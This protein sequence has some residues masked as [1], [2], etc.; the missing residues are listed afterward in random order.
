MAKLVIFGATG[1]AG[2]R[3]GAEAR[4]RGHD[5]VG[6]A[7]NVDGISGDFTARAGS[8]HDAPFVAEVAKGADVLVVATPAREDADGRKLLDAVP[9]LAKAAVAEGARLAFVG[10]A[11]SL[12]VVEG[13]P[14]LIDTP[15]FP[16][17]YKP[18]AGNHADVLAAV[19]ELPSDVDWFY[20]SPAAEF[21]AWAAGERTGKFRLGGDVLLA[22]ENGASK[23]GGDDYAIAFVDEIEQ[24]KHS[25]RR[26]TVAY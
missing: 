22:D 10:G 12:H 6:V 14:R 5:V 7:R 25:R 9:S 16:D 4:R 18:E 17:E 2:G 1:Y 20:V 15:E 11:G 24:P 13:G 26:F 21:G 19:R 23:I 3:I 8:L